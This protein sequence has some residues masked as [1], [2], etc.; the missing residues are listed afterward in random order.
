MVKVARVI[1]PDPSVHSAYEPFYEAYKATYGA[2]LSLRRD[3]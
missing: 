2:V 1:D 3:L